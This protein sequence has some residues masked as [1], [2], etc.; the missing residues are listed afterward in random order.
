MKKQLEIK[1]ENNSQ[2]PKELLS[3]IDSDKLKEALQ[4]IRTHIKELSDKEELNFNSIQS[5]PPSF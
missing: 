2:N 1:N 4:N 5:P 3:P